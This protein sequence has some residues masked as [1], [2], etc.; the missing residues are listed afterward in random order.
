MFDFYGTLA[1]WAD[2]TT[3]SYA[4]VFAAHGYR[5]PTDVLNAYYARY[6]GMEH[7]AQSESEADYERWVRGRL[8]ELTAACRVDPAHREDV[9]DALRASDQGE[10]IAYPEAADTL[11]EIRRRGVAIGV[12]SNWGWELE[13]FLRQVGLRELVDSAVTSA[14]AGARKPHPRIF[15][16]ACTSLR[17][18]PQDVLFVGDSWVPDVIGPKQ[19]GMSAIHLWREDEHQGQAPPPTTPDDVRIGDLSAL[20]GIIDGDR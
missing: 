2:T 10:M 8:G 15:E 13:A 1:H 7:V 9:I 14:R 11:R 5:L 17:V 19:A 4:T 20:L 6:D 18:E 16:R 3:S 12:C